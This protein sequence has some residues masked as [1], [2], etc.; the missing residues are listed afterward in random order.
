MKNNAPRKDEQRYRPAP[1]AMSEQEQNR[2]KLAAWLLRYPIPY[3]LIIQGFLWAL[4]FHSKKA[5]VIGMGVGIICYGLYMLIGFHLKWCHV[6][7]WWQN[8]AHQKM[9][10][11]H[12]NWNNINRSEGYG[13]PFFLITFGV[14]ITVV[15]ILAA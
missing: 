10:P 9:T 6:F 12:C 3:L 2:I 11:D 14:V 5:M 13:L 4:A 8:V 1:S 15:G 7:C